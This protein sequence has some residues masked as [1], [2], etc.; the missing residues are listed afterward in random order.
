[1]YESSKRIEKLWAGPTYQS[2][3]DS[4]VMDPRDGRPRSLRTQPPSDTSELPPPNFEP[5][6]SSPP[7]RVSSG[8]PLE[9][10]QAQDLHTNAHMKTE[11]MTPTMQ[12]GPFALP[13]SFAPWPCSTACPRYTQASPNERA[14]EFTSSAHGLQHAPGG[15]ACFPRGRHTTKYKCIYSAIVPVTFS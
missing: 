3:T 14:N 9:H 10:F 6:L 2:H 1:M 12:S 7:G 13:A 5:P 15:R 11:G 4:L 8:C